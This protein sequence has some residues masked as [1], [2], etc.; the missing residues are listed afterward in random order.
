VNPLD[1]LIN[2]AGTR[3]SFRHA[4]ALSG[5]GKVRR[6]LRL[7][8]RAA[9]AGS[10]EAAYC[11]AR[12]YL[13]GTGVPVS[14]AHAIDWLHRAGIHGHVDAQALLAE[15]YL[16]GVASGSPVTETARLG[17]ANSV[18]DTNS[19]GDPD[20]AAANAWARRA[21]QGGSPT[22]QALLGYILTSGPK[23][24]RNLDE[25]RLWYERSAAAGCP[26]GHLGYALSLAR[27]NSDGGDTQRRMVD[28]AKRAAH[29]I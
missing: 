21:A 2:L 8:V 4:N 23:T 13:E 22:G 27:I 9:R 1:W 18:F 28:H 14:R 10:S 12:F 7:Y 16:H 29:C 15:L 17:S 11:V 20:F 19:T 24:L 3:V 25:A 5:K 6:A 26:H